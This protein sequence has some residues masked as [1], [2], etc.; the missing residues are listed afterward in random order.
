M[1]EKFQDKMDRIYNL[2]VESEPAYALTGAGVSTD[3][4]IPDF[5]GS[6][7]L[8]KDRDPMD[9][10]SRRA[11][12][13]HPKTFFEFWADRFSKLGDASP[14]ITHKVLAELE[15]S[16][17]LSGVITQNI[18]GLHVEAGSQQVFQLHGN[19]KVSR[20]ERCG[21]ELP[22]DRL[23]QR[24]KDTGVPRCEDCDA[25]IRPD[26][27]LF[28]EQLPEAFT[29]AKEKLAGSKLLFVLGTS[30]GVYPVASLVPYFKKTS[31]RIVI[32]NNQ[33]TSYDDLA[34]LVHHGGLAPAMEA[35]ENRLD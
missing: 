20:C 17:L 1:N 33:S 14:N 15:E 11:L 31:G 13:D 27:V 28:N 23:L 21:R 29:E 3:S 18:D 7:G 24:F 2:L 4:G 34:E 5:R 22:T 6:D 25:L 30:L 12:H 32:I 26:V 35:L 8:W 10:A 16:G 19:F 9:V